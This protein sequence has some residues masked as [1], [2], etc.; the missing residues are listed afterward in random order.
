MSFKWVTLIVYI[1]I[2]IMKYRDRKIRI[3]QHHNLESNER[4]R[5]PRSIE[6]FVFNLYQP[7]NLNKTTIYSKLKIN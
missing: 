6:K 4:I 5:R 3:F 2:V 1:I 7:L